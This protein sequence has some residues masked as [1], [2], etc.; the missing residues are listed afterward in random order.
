MKPPTVTLS[1]PYGVDTMQAKAWLQGL[2][3]GIRTTHLGR[4]YIEARRGVATAS[5]WLGLSLPFAALNLI[6]GNWLGWVWLAGVAFWLAAL[7]HSIRDARHLR[8]ELEDA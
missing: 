6:G 1:A 8:R 5:G 7:I 4:D 3:D 2:H